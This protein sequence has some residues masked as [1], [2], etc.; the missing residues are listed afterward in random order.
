MASKK[1]RT[2]S[3]L[4]HEV[5]LG[6]NH[7]IVLVAKDTTTTGHWVPYQ[8]LAELLGYKAATNHWAGILPVGIFR[9]ASVS[10][11]EL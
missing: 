6:G 10:H 9:A 1:V 8:E 11:T 2:L 3:Q 5:R 4:I 7:R